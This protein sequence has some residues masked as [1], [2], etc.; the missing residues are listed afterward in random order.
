MMVSSES[1]G[2]SA[3]A[4]T[5]QGAIARRIHEV[6]ARRQNSL[7]KPN[8]EIIWNSLSSR[9]SGCENEDLIGNSPQLRKLLDRVHS[10]APTD[11]SVLIIGETGSGKELIVRAIHNGSARRNSPLVKVNCGAIPPGLV[12]SEFFGHVKGAFTG[13]IDKRVGRF[14]LANGGTIFLDEVGELP[15]DAQVKLLRVLQ[16]QEFEPVRSSR[17]VRVR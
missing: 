13:A 1:I 4:G 10:A 2:Y 9:R 5:G 17:T 14:E 3:N 6:G 7:L 11:A 15:L 8:R 16:E 12:E